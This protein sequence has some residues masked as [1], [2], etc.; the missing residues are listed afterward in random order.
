MGTERCPASQSFLFFIRS[1]SENRRRSQHLASRSVYVKYATVRWILAEPSQSCSEQ[2]FKHHHPSK[3]AS[4]PLPPLFRLLELF[5]LNWV[6]LC[7]LPTAI[8][9]A[10]I[11]CKYLIPVEKH[12]I[13]KAVELKRENLSD[14]VHFFCQ[15]AK[16]IPINATLLKIK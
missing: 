1:V 4:Q 13:L 15:S 6:T 9:E 3:H 14:F 7:K 12:F 10:E 11:F 2:D 8:A 16:R 5:F